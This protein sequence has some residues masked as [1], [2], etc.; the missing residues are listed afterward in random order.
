MINLNYGEYGFYKMFRMF[1]FLLYLEEHFSKKKSMVRLGQNV[2]IFERSFQANLRTVS[3]RK[4][5]IESTEIIKKLL[6]NV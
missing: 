2:A 5:A 6:R 3:V 1:T 4:Q